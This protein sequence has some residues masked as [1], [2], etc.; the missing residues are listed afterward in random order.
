MVSTVTCIAWS[1]NG[2]GHRLSGTGFDTTIFAVYFDRGEYFRR[3]FSNLGQVHGLI[4]STVNI[5]ALT[6]TATMKTWDKIIATLGMSSPVVVAISPEKTNLTCWVREKLTI[7]EVFTPIVHKLKK[8]C[9]KMPRMI[10]SCKTCEE[11]AILYQFFQASLQ[12]KFTEPIGAPNLSR[13]RMV[14][15]YMS[16]TEKNVL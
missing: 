7:E 14:D 3:E 13:Y 5:M 2:I 6:A 12:L 10:I 4:P 1:S 9:T 15:M 16:A 11:C 8:K